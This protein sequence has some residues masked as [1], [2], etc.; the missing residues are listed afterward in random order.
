MTTSPE[1]QGHDETAAPQRSSLRRFTHLF[2]TLHLP[3]ISMG[4]GM[5][6]TA[7]V[8]PELTKSLGEG[9][10]A[11][12][13][14]FII[15]QAGSVVAPLPT[16]YLIDR[17]GRRPTLLAGPVILAGTSFLVAKVAV[18]GTLA[19]FMVY[20][21]IGGIGAQMWM[22]S[23]IIVIADTASQATRGRQI[24]SMFGVQGFG[25]LAGPAVG[26]LAAVTIGLWVPFV[27]HGVIVLAAMVPSYLL[28]KE[29]RPP[30]TEQAGAGRTAASVDTS[31]RELL[32]PPIPT[33]F[34]VQF[35]AGVTR[36]G[37][38]GGGVI[39]VYATFAY[40]MSP[41]ELGSL[42]SMMAIVG[43]PMTFTAGFIMD[44]FGR[45]YTIV[46]GLALSGL[47]M[48]FLAAT[49][50][51]SLS[52]SYFVAAF[53]GVHL[54]VHIISGNMQT[55]GTDVAPAGSRGRFFGVSRL[56][57]Q[58][59]SLLSPTSFAVLSGLASYTV[60]FAFLG[61]SAL[62]GSVIVAVFIKETLHRYPTP[63]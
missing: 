31:W 63:T 29:T 7:V 60:A 19:E 37:V 10:G 47:A 44:R 32:V 58:T 38:F 11:A 26:G 30:R 5:G 41:L 28:Q 14:V 17:F 54:A 6:M 57:A 34:L 9:A 55:L 36:G 15:Y 16:G 2:L 8:L 59:G 50:L 18:D 40:G 1:T 25:T 61:G 21:F 3:A 56:V 49:W 45:K 20:R 13:M 51:G 4:L 43:I 33:V 39:L 22:L 23:R 53:I 12:I 48:F 46:P 27:L 52:V 62:I 35:L 42:R 24:T